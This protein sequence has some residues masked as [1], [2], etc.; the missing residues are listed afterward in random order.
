MKTFFVVALFVFVIPAFVTSTQATQ[1]PMPTVCTGTLV[2]NNK[3][4]LHLDRESAPCNAIIPKRL[5][6]EVLKSCH[7][8]GTCRITGHPGTADV[9]TL[10]TLARKK[11]G[12]GKI[13]KKLKR[14]EGATRQKAFT[15]AI[16]R[17]FLIQR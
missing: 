17:S 4:F 9:R 10:K 8:G 12:A 1:L 11:T 7:I 16:K 13:A 14:I 6:K 5:T 3:G 15:V 2:R